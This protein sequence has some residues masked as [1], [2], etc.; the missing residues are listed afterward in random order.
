MKISL[1]LQREPFGEIIE[2]TLEDFFHDFLGGEYTIKWDAEKKSVK[3]E[4]DKTSQWLCNPHLNI[5]FTPTCLREK[6]EPIKKEFSYSTIWWKRPIQLLYWYIATNRLTAQFFCPYQ[7]MVT[8]GL[9]HGDDYLIIGGNNR[10]RM[11]DRKNRLSYV[12]SK[13]GFSRERTE[14][15]LA[16]RKKYPF[17][18]IPAVQKIASDFLW[19]AEEYISGTPVNRIPDKNKAAVVT[20][21]ALSHINELAEKT[22][23]HVDSENYRR[24]LVGRI[25]E[26]LTNNLLLNP[27][28]K[29]ALL[30]QM[31]KLSA[32]LNQV[33]SGNAPL[34]LCQSH[35]DF[36][37]GNILLENDRVWLIDWEYTRV[38]QKVYDLLVF[39]LGTRFGGSYVLKLQAFL[40]GE[41]SAAFQLPDQLIQLDQKERIVTSIL[42]LLEELDLYL[43][44]N[45]NP[46]FTKPTG[47][48]INY[49][50]NVDGYVELIEATVNG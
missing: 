17:L 15:E 48:L 43:E 14:I 20:Q 16:V 7:L 11:L 23:S 38:R 39:V 40:I 10:I 26:S 2:R 21:K 31:D 36:Q 19:Y 49:M 9:S 34:A 30:K 8:P 22:L 41:N 1:L 47:G 18:P 5:V 13:A 37:P 27:E 12:I 44:E 28:E 3:C 24:E 25:S 46:L 45:N 33:I 35:G 6:L 32:L 4:E 29:D 50:C 42:F